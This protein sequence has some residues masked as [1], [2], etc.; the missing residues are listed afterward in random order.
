MALVIA[1]VMVMSMGVTA[2]AASQY[3][4]TID[5]SSNTSV[6]I[7]GKTYTA[8]KL[9]D[10]TYTGSSAEDP[11]AYSIDSDGDGAWA[12]STLTSGITADANG[13]YNNTTYG[14]KFTPTAA[15]SSVYSITSTMTDAQARALADAL[16]ATS[17]SKNSAVTKTAQASGETATIDV[18]AP[19]YWLVYGTAKPKDPNANTDETVAAC[20]LT[21]TDPTETVVPKVSIPTLDKKIT[22]QHVLDDAGKA[23]TAEVGSTVSFEIDSVVPDIT[24]Y[25]AYTFEINDTM[26]DGLSFTG[27][28]TANTINTLAITVGGTAL[29]TDKYTVEHTVGS[30][31]FKITIPFATLQTLTKGAAIVVTYD[32]TVNDGALTT[33]FE[34]N[35]ANLTYSNNPYDTSDKDTTPDKKV[36]VI[37]INLDVDKYTGADTED[38]YIS[39]EAYEALSE[40]EKAEYSIVA[41][42]E[43]GKEYMKPGTSATKLAG[44]QFKVFKGATQPADSAQ[45]WYKWD[46]NNKKVTWV[47]KA[48]A[49]IFTS[50]TTGGFNP[51][52]RG[53]EAEKTGTAY[54]L[55]EIAAPTGYNPLDAPITFTLTGAYD[56]TG[57]TEKATITASAG[58]VT[59][60]TIDLSTQASQPVVTE[61]VLNQS[62]TELPS[63]GGIGTTIF[64]VIGAI[65]VLGAGILLVT[66]R[67]MNA[68]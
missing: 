1:M 49:D 17:V 67:R 30:K 19:G 23:A 48:D 13:V 66:R 41:D 8:Y 56:G 55:L 39:T 37:D 60:G 3:T 7:D 20:A 21:T 68:N 46:D 54:G 4:I 62:G 28:D 24:G 43:T 36:Y 15:D 53:L 2:F 34:N 61:P 35:T 16:G 59:G 22:G 25:T 18:E 64:Y 44:A 5:N 11:H 47:A 9:F 63:T 27:T 57:A 33:D 26:S 42:P 14:L 50:T 40:E 32:A 45:A 52:V 6:S 10:V 12:W 31:S 38:E 65:L 29:A 58:S 51:Q